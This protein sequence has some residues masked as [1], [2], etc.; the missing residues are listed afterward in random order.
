MQIGDHNY[1]DNR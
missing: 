1:L